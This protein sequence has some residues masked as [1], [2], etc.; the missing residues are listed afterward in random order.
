MMVECVFSLPL[1]YECKIIDEAKPAI[2]WLIEGTIKVNCDNL[3]HFG[4]FG[5]LDTNYIV[6]IVIVLPTGTFKN[7]LDSYVIIK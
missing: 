5:R 6:V 2:E 4:A 1:G 3:N 7:R